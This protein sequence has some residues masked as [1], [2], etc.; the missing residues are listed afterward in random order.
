MN[1]KVGRPNIINKYRR[2][3]LIRYRK[4]RSISQVAN[5]FDISYTSV[6]KIIREVYPS[7]EVYKENNI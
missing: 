7:K 2:R 6:Y 5:E 3:V 1:N 4:L